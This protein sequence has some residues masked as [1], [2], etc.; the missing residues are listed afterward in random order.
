MV[1]KGAINSLVL[2][3]HL[4]SMGTAALFSYLLYHLPSWG[5]TLL[6]E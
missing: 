4:Y 2:P 5:V 3:M 1:R 6:S